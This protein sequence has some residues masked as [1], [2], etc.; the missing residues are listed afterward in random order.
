MTK[1]EVGNQIEARCAKCKK[2]T[3]HKIVDFKKDETIGK[4]CCDE[5]QYQHAYRQ[6][7]VKKTVEEK[8]ATLAAKKK[9]K[10][11][12]DFEEMM[13]GVD[14]ESAINYNIDASFEIDNIVN[15]STFG[16]GKVLELITPD[17][18]TVRFR[19]GEKVLLCVISTDY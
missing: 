19:E 1:P 4:V 10:A 11:D 6:P 14:Q 13:E 18:M 8:N 7:R 17:K 16:L 5:C 2:I 3:G 9:I 15:H 12:L